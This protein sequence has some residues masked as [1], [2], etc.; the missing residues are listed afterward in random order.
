MLKNYFKIALR[1]LWKHKGYSFINIAGLAVGMACA[2][3][4]LL[5]VQDELS[6]DRFHANARTLFRVEQD[7]K[8][9]QGKFHVNVT[10]YGMRDAL[11]A[12]IPEIRD[13]TRSA[14]TGTLLVRQG[15]KAFYENRVT[16]VDPSFL[17]MFTFPMIRGDAGTALSGP[18]SI[19]LSEDLAKK[20]FGTENAVGR[21][22]NINNQYPVTVSAVMKNAPAN[23]ILQI[24]ALI[25]V[26]F[27]KNLGIDI[28]D[29]GRNQIITYVQLH[30]KSAV[31]AVNAKITRLVLDR[32]LASWRGDAENWKRIQADPEKLKQYKSYVGPDFT[33][34]PVVD[35]NLYGH[36]GFDP[37]N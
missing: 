27:L 30:E 12:E 14:R 21:T 19:V 3:F 2:L 1:N 37:N 29:W 22:L 26:E 23:S 25:S 10:P 11:K 7:Q 16:A 5:W 6:Y 17:Q 34:M 20:Y 32:T 36:F 28:G 4:I 33:V 13:A 35:I 31:S 18:G 15:E 24:D 8:G 9:G